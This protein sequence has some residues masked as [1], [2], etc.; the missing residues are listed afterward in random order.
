MLLL[1]GGLRPQIYAALL[2]YKTLYMEL[3]DSAV[4]RQALEFALF[5]PNVVL[6]SIDS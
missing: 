4:L 3:Y 5:E 1:L 6:L 2:A